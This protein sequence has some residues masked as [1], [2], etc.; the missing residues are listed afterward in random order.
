MYGFA[1]ASA[2][3]FRHISEWSK[4]RATCRLDPKIG[5]IK[6][7]KVRAGAHLLK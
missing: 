4:E 3:T 1:L 5:G 7:T 2:R 6:N